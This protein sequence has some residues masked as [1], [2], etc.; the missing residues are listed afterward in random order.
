[1]KRAPLVL[2]GT[3]CGLVAVIGYHTAVP[4]AS[5]SASSS[6][7]GGS[8]LNIGATSTTAGSSSASTRVK[9]ATASTTSK[10]SAGTTRSAVGEDV[11]YQYG[12]IEL[13]VTESGGRITTVSVVKE[14]STD[15]HSQQ[16]NEYAL[17]ELRGQALAAQSATLDGVSGASYTSAAYEQSLQSALDKLKA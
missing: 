14:D 5:A 6:S 9:T 7:G 4:Q 17:P 2:T 3:A 16:I 15:P 12:D 1:M 13:K 10:H 11:Q 8:T